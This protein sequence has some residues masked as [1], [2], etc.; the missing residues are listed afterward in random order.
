MFSE[1]LLINILYPEPG[2][3]LN[4]AEALSPGTY[5]LSGC[6][7]GLVSSIISTG[8]SKDNILVV[9]SPSSIDKNVVVTKFVESTL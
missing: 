3:R 7:I 1:T 6:E 4:V 8:P 9:L 2:K 5:Q